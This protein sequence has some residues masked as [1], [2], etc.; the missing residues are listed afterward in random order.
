MP[1][2][3][4]TV[5]HENESSIQTFDH[6]KDNEATEV[7]FDD[8]E[9]QPRTAKGLTSKDPLL[10]TV[11]APHNLH[12]PSQDPTLEEFRE[13]RAALFLWSKQYKSLRVADANMKETATIKSENQNAD[14]TLKKS[15]SDIGALLQ[16]SNSQ[17]VKKRSRVKSVSF[18]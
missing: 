5:L 10:Q 12:I 6:E 18:V 2:T 7:I 14:N 17:E 3:M 1:S 9:D 16:N 11:L 13:R 8:D 4:H 15:L